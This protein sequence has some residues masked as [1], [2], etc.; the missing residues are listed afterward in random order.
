MRMKVA[1]AQIGSVLFDTSATMGRVERCCREASATG[2]QLLVLPEALI[3]G[4]PKGLDFGVS[5]RNRTE[6]GRD[7]FLRYFRSAILVPGQETEMLSSWAKELDIHIVVGVIERDGWIAFRS[8]HGSDPQTS[9][10]CPH[11]RGARNLG[12]RRRL[13]HAG[14]RYPDWKN[15]LG[16]LLGKLHAA[17]SPESL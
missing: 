17:L 13:N 5:V 10:A 4:Y 3:G 11:W 16:N 6:A 14:R 1:I 7:L 15:R 9:Q 8:A 12:P 2:A